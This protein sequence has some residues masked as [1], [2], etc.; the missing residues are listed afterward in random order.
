MAA[1]T[2]AAASRGRS[3]SRHVLA[4][5]GGERDMAFADLGASL[6]IGERAGDARARRAAARERAVPDRPPPR[7]S[8]SSDRITWANAPAGGY[9]FR[10]HGRRA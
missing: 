3:R 1:A 7:S 2:S 4:E 5:G 6:E 9:E 8:A 10:R